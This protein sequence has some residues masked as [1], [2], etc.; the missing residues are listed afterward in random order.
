MEKKKYT[1]TSKD[2]KTYEEV[3]VG[4][5]WVKMT[6][7]GQVYTGKINGESVTVKPNRKKQETSPDFIVTKSVLVDEKVNHQ[8]M[9]DAIPSQ[10]DDDIPF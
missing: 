3:M 10:G 2:G 5:L 9:L 8:Q 4:S 1:W 6:K 7:I